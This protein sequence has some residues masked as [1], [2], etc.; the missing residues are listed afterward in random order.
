MTGMLEEEKRLTAYSMVC[1]YGITEERVDPSF[2]HEP[3]QGDIQ[4]FLACT[5]R[6]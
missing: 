2:V 4:L 1:A 3:S 6:A 5:V